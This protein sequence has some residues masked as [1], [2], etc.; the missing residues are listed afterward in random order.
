MPLPK[1]KI[2]QSL[3]LLVEKS[4]VMLESIRRK[5]ADSLRSPSLHPSKLTRE[6]CGN[7]FIVVVIV[8]PHLIEILLNDV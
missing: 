6:I 7:N 1:I 2:D 3:C 8:G 4:F 5:H